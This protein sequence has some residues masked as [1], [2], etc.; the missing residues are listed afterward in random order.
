[1]LI[2][3]GRNPN[4]IAGHSLRI[5]GVNELAQRKCDPTDIQLAGRWTSEAYHLYLRAPDSGDTL[6]TKTLLK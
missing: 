6:I 5:G 2:Q 1:M 4:G 3:V